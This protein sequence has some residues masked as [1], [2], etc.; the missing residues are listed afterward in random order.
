MADQMTMH[1]KFISIIKMHYDCQSQDQMIQT[2][3]PHRAPVQRGIGSALLNA[4]VAVGHTPTCRVTA[5]DHTL[6]CQARYTLQVGEP[7][8]TS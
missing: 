2:V 4:P 7:G 1:L 3:L 6:T 8:N 5:V